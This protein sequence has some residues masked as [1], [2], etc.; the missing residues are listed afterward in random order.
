MSGEE[1]GII[2]NKAEIFSGYN[3]YGLKD[4][5]S[6]YGN[7]KTNEDDIGYADAVKQLDKLKTWL[8]V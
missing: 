3:N 5:D 6:V 7:N 4:T 2:N 8:S 1:T